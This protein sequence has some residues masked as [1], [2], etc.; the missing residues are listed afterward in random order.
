[1]RDS[2]QNLIDRWTTEEGKVLHKEIIA[3]L[4]KEKPLEELNGLKRI[5]DKFD[6]RG[7]SFPKEYSAYDYKGKLLKQVAGSLKFKGI[8]V[9]NIDFTYADIQTTEWTNCRFSNVKFYGANLEQLRITNCAFENVLFQN[10][11][12]S[13]SYLNIRNGTKSGSFKNVTFKN[14]Q[15]NE[16]RFSFPTIEDC[17]FDSCNLHAADFDGGRFKD[18]KF[19]GEVNSPWF[20]KHSIKEFEPNLIFNQ[21]NKRLF[22]NEMQNIDFSAATLKYV[23]FSKDLNLSQ[24]KFGQG[25]KFESFEKLEKDIY[26]MS[27]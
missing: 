11:K 16:T 7:I 14:S 15:L 18:C 12:L 13:Y 26:A 17:I 8:K 22:T 3:R 20:R 25:T 27:V 6:L 9:D 21:V 23:T 24:C 2:R 10:T 5:E 1:M 19:I 4:T